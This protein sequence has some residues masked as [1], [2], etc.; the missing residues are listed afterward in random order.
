MTHVLQKLYDIFG[1][2][3]LLPI[4][5]KSKIPAAQAWQRISYAD[6]M[7]S[8]YQAELRR[9][10]QRGGNIGVVLGPSSNGLA[11]IDIDR[12]ALVPQFLALN[13]ALAQ[14]TRTRAKR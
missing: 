3:V 9:L 11:A 10:I 12:D 4:G 1:Q 13:P 8:S 5:F 6:S 14:T 2:V 7:A